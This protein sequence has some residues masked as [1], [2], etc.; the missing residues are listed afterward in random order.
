MSAS[1]GFNCIEEYSL[2]KARSRLTS[3]PGWECVD[4]QSLLLHSCLAS[5]H[6][7]VSKHVLNDMFFKFQHEEVV[8]GGGG[9]ARPLP[10][11]AALVRSSCFWNI[12][13]AVNSAI[14]HSILI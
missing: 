14:N 1:L 4:K 5:L 3:G 8:S 10:L 12:H 13:P 2:L 6:L 9:K 7:G 11:A